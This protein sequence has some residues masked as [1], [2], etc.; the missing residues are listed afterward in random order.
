MMR[1][2]L[3]VSIRLPCLAVLASLPAPGDGIATLVPLP[4]H[5]LTPCC[6]GDRSE[7][8]TDFAGDGLELWIGVIPAE[9]KNEIADVDLPVSVG[10]L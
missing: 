7:L 1:S 8:E 10:L 5:S 6:V 2:E 9:I 4:A 3:A